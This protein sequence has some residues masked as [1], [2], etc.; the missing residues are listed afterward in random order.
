M[1]P[2]HSPSKG[3][4]S[5]FHITRAA[6]TQTRV[7]GGEHLLTRQVRPQGNLIA[8]NGFLVRQSLDKLDKFRLLQ[9]ITHL[10]CKPL[11][12]R[13]IAWLE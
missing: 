9:N 4:S 3:E 2:K 11:R 7:S 8:S 10:Q 5:S 1:K 13:G 6:A 12:R